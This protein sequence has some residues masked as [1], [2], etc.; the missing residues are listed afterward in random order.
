VQRKGR[1]GGGGPSCP[2]KGMDHQTLNSGPDKQVPPAK[3]ESEGHA[4]RARRKA[5]DHPI[6][7]SGPDKRVP[8]NKNESEMHA[9]RAR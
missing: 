1:N 2:T 5:I 9:C 3:K 6:L 8:P 7:T 4:R